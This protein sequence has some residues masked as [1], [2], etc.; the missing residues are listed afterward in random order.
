MDF[1]TFTELL[2]ASQQSIV[3]HSHHPQKKPYYP[4]AVIPTFPMQ[5]LIYGKR[6]LKTI[7]FKVA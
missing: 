5:S 7:P 1:S 6:N 2:Q 3:E 4:L